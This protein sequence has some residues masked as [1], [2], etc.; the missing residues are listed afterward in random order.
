M[1]SRAFSLMGAAG[2]GFAMAAT[3]FAAWA[4]RPARA[5]FQGTPRLGQPLVPPTPAA[6]V[7]GAPQPIEVQA[8]DGEHFVV[9]T[10]EPR[11]VQQVGQ[12]STAQQMLVTVVT[13]YTV[14]EGRLVPVEHVRPP[15]G[16]HV[17]TLAD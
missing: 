4:P 17:V 10:R 13:H 11:L 12:E 6:A 15:T 3:L 2:L 5:Q 7:A 1:E 16:F 8:L 14:R 9:A